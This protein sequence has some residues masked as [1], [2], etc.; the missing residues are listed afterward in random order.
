[1]NAFALPQRTGQVPLTDDH[2]RNAI[3]SACAG[4]RA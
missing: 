3:A 2:R 1:M 4:D